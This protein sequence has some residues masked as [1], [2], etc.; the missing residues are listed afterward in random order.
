MAWIPTWTIEDL[1]ALDAAIATGAKR[2]QYHD[3]FIEY[4][5]IQNM[6]AA[7]RLIFSWLF[8]DQVGR[9][10]RVYGSFSKGLR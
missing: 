8:P 4:Q 2:V 9:P 6:L 7:R 5:S 1:A 3:K 10:G